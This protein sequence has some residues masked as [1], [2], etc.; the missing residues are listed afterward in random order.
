MLLLGKAQVGLIINDGSI[1]YL[2]EHVLSNACADS[3]TWLT[4]TLQWIRAIINVLN[5]TCAFPTMTS[6][7][8]LPGTRPIA[9]AEKPLMK[10]IYGRHRAFPNTQ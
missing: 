5:Y 1:I 9:K 4:G 10:V 3:L 7:L 6:Q 2:K 8:C